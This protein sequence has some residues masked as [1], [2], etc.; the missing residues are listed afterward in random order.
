MKRNDSKNATDDRSLPVNTIVS[1]RNISGDRVCAGG[2]KDI[3][4]LNIQR[5]LLLCN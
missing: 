2:D 3:F 4:L 5:R 1:K